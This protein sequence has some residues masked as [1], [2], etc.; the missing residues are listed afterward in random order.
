MLFRSQKKPDDYVVATGECYTVKQF[1]NV[2][3]KMLGMNIFWQGKGLK[4]I[5]YIKKKNQN[6]IV[7]KIDKKYFRPNEVDYLKGDASKALKKLK[8]K[9]KYT[10]KSLVKDMLEN[11]M[12]L[13]RK[14]L[15][16]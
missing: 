15:Y 10:F 2:A 8:F 13:A 3:S 14:E 4:E 9:P 1:I 6:K 7:I 12:I 11:D 5:G 16:K